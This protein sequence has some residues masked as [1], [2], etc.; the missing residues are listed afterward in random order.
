M[1]PFTIDMSNPFSSGF[2]RDHGG[3]HSGGHRSTDWYIEFGMDLGAPRGTDVRA[4][5]DAHITRFAAHVP[6]RDT[7]KVFGAQLFMRSPNDKMGAF[8]THLTDVPGG[9]AAGTKIRR[10]DVLGKVHH[11]HGTPHLHLALV[12]IIG[13]APAGRYVGVDLFRHFVSTAN[14]T[15][16]SHVTFHQSG[17]PPTV[18]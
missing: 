18:S 3:P 15:A 9:I 16:V 17:S 14:S 8:Y 10:G 12:E 5:F 7:A 1:P 4:A 2:T 11:G 6:S 13:G